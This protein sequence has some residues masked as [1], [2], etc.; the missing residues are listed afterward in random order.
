MSETKDISAEENNSCPDQ[1]AQMHNVSKAF[2]I[3]LGDQARSEIFTV[4]ID[5]RSLIA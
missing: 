1:P 5:V 2:Y 3:S 4:R